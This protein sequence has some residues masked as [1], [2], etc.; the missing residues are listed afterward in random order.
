MGGRLGTGPT[1][2][3]E[4]IVFGTVI[5]WTNE[6]IGYEADPRQVEKLFVELELDGEGVKGVVTPGVKV[7]SHQAQSEKELRDSEHTFFRGLA[8][9]ANLL[10]AEGNL[11]VHG[12]ARGIGHTSQALKTLGR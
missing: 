6:G 1:D 4:T 12:Q 7:L 3:K 11:Q 5:R 8:A 9:R 2:D 10:A